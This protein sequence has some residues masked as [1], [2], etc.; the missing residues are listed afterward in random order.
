MINRCHNERSDNYCRYGGRGIFVCAQWRESFAAFLADMGLRPAGTSIDR[1]D[2][3]G[4][5]EPGN[6]RWASTLEQVRNRRQSLIL[7]VNGAAKTVEEWSREVS[8]SAET[9]RRRKRAGLSDY[10]AIYLR[11]RN[12]NQYASREQEIAN[13]QP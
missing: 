9:I 11:R 12:T 5:Y 2:N 7:V 13:A 1:I 6:C 4:S 8:V 3:D 10:D